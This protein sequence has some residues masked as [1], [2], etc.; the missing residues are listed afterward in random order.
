M[1]FIKRAL[2]LSAMALFSLSAV[3]E[4]HYK[5]HISVGA[6]GGMTY[7]KMSFYPSVKQS[8][9]PGMIIG[10]TFSYAEEK[11]FGLTAELCIEQRGWKENFEE[12][13][14]QFSYSRRL[15]YIQLPLLTH[16]SFGSSKFKG[17][18]NLGP[19][20]AYMIGSSIS[21]DFD[22]RNYQSVPGFPVQNRMNE[23]MTMEIKNKF[24]YGISAGLGMEYF[25]NRR[26]SVALEGRFY[27]GLGNIYPDKK[28][29]TFSASRGMSIQV[30][31]AYN[32]RLK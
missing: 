27:Y 13:N 20:V 11:L 3:S 10:A 19:E 6:K 4:T 21:A 30:T 25:V 1:R 8:M 22:Y 23:Q 26:H 17:Y 24:D 29:D 2:V 31:L 14:S 16:I 12:D 7:S 15:T 18:V 5:P 9:L 28:K 32:M